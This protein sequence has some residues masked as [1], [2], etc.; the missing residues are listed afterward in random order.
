VAV[1]MVIFFLSFFISQALAFNQVESALDNKSLLVKLDPEHGF[2]KGERIVVLS[3]SQG[4]L[5]AIGKVIRVQSD[6]NPETAVVEVEEII[7]NKMIL[8]SDAVELLT[9]EVLEKHHITGHISLML[10]QESKIPARYKD[11]AY[12]GVFNSDGHTL[13]DKEWLVSIPQIQYGLT[14]SFTVKVLTGLYLDGFANIGAKA[15]VM[16]NQWGQMT[17]NALTSRQINRDD[18]VFQTGL[19]LT[20][21]ANGR[22][23]SHLVIN[24]RI[25]GIE[26]DN[27]EVDKLNLFPESDIRT[28]YEYVTDDWDRVL[29]GPLFNFQTQTVGGTLSHMWIWDT[30]H[31]NL[32]IATKDVSELKFNKDGYYVLFDFFWRF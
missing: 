30:F 26:E 22:F 14:D 23:Q 3:R 18:W 12:M 29:F 20:L 5:V 2:V 10:G 24:A 31:L 21:P 15:R 25:E 1:A 28:I 9:V 27:P 17:L 7:G 11:L 6:Q 32:G 8:P 13:A 16:R 19:V 4:S